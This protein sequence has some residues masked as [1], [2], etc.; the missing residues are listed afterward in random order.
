MNFHSRSWRLVRSNLVWTILVGLPACETSRAQSPV[1]TNADVQAIRSEMQQLREDYERRMDALEKRLEQIET[2]T[3]GTNHPAPPAAQAA[4]TNE[5]STAETY[6]NFARHQFQENTDTRDMELQQ[7]QLRPVKERLEQMLNNYVDISGYFRAGYG[8]DD[9]GGVQP[10]FQA[11]GAFAK[12]RL[13]N[14]TENYGELAF[15]KNWYPADL[16]SSDSNIRPDGTPSGPIARTQ[17]RLAFYDPFGASGTADTFQTTLPEAYSELGN[18]IPAQ[19]SLKFW[20][21]SRFYRRQ[22]IAIND[23]F[24]YNMSGTG[25]GFEDLELPFGK[26]AF[27]WIGNGSQSGVYSSDIAALPDPNN[28]A[29]FSKQSLDLSLYEVPVPWGKAEFAVVGALGGSGKD[30]LGHQAPDSDGFALTAIHTH[31]HFLSPDGFNRFSLQYGR[32]AA[33]TFTS[34]YETTTFTNGTFIVPDDSDSW[35]FRATESFVAQLC[36]HVSFSPAVV[37]QYTDYHNQL[38]HVQWFSTGARPIYHFDEHFGVALEGG[39]DYVDNSGIDQCGTLYKV[40]LS[41]QLSL[42][43]RFL[44]RPVIRAYVTY[45]RWTSPFR[46]AVGGNDYANDTSGWTWG[47]QM[48]SWW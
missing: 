48:E 32:G 15:G 44:S 4:A 13:G 3:G 30:S 10:A 24:F 43:N 2:A 45:A 18:V 9:K 38:G 19:P 5:L 21:G 42:G 6:A 27:A 36:D 22:D 31:D 1:S 11:P 46:G 29:G 34:G 26:L 12:Y 14:E 40:T 25:G 16:F 17:V 47:M 35:R 33:K 39:M 37:Y 23:F 28:K 8:R 41:P 7:E 20:A